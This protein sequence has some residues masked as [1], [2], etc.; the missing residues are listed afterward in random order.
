ML[1]RWCDDR[2]GVIVRAVAAYRLPPERL[3]GEHRD[4]IKTLVIRMHFGGGITKWKQLHGVAEE[5]NCDEMTGLRAELEALRVT[6]F[7][8]PDW[9]GWVE[10]D[11]RRLQNPP[12]NKTEDEASRSTF[13][14]LLQREE[15]RVL[16]AV[17]DYAGRTNWRVLALC[18]DGLIIADR[19][20]ETFDV[21]AAQRAI[22]DRTGY[23]LC[24]TEKPLFHGGRLPEFALNA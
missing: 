15:S 9:Q 22:V 18:F 10:A 6:A 5:A 12:H 8:H 2:V 16:E 11:L 21:A 1:A 20:G 4:A 13:A 24:L 7:E 3:P 23:E 14:R 17:R 19:A